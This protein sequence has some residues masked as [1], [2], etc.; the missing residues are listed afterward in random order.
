MKWLYFTHPATEG[1]TE[2]PDEDGVQE[3]HEARGWVLGEKPEELIFVPAPGNAEDTT[4]SEWITLYHPETTAVHDFPNN[5]EAIAGAQESGWILKESPEAIAS[6][7]GTP[8]GETAA[9]KTPEPEPAPK[10][11]KRRASASAEDEKE[12]G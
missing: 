9:D 12:N 1:T 3:W 10:T 8:A 11:S 6:S 5:P 4:A 2:V 7:E